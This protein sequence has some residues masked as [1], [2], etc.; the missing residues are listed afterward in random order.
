[1]QSEEQG[2][3]CT[4]EEMATRERLGEA[5]RLTT[6]FAKWLEDFIP[7]RGIRLLRIKYECARESLVLLAL[8]PD[9]HYRQVPGQSEAWSPEGVQDVRALLGMYRQYRKWLMSAGGAEEGKSAAGARRRGGKRAVMSARAVL[10]RLV[11]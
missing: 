2:A 5:V 7:A 10:G 3:G 8:W 1:M 9:K 4:D 11:M 6:D